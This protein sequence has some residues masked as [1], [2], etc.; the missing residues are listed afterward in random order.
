MKIIIKEISSQ[1][2]KWKDETLHGE[3]S[4]TAGCATL[5]RRRFFQD[6][7]EMDVEEC[8]FIQDTV[9]WRIFFL[10]YR[11]FGFEHQ[12]VKLCVCL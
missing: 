1:D 2:V 9:Q 10:T 6:P 4:A 3:A 12:G 8:E 11:T 7:R 5:S